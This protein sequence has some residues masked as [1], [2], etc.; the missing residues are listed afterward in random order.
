VNYFSHECGSTETE[1][2]SVDKFL[3]GSVHL[4]KQ[5]PDIQN[6][7]QN[8]ASG[9]LHLGPF[10]VLP[11]KR[12]KAV[13]TN[14]IFSFKDGIAVLSP[15]EQTGIKVTLST[16]IPNVSGSDLGRGMS[17]LVLGL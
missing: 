9:F 11:K 1:E 5:S 12:P 6:I 8:T 15:N 13:L 14:V 3:N 10:W 2:R 16:C 4:W 17:Y 7:L